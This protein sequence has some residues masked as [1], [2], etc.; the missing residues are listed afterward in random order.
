MVPKRYVVT[1]V[2]IAAFIVV[3]IGMPLQIIKSIWCSHSVVRKQ[4]CLM[5]L[6]TWEYVTFAWAI[7]HTFVIATVMAF[8]NVRPWRRSYYT[9]IKSTIFKCLAAVMVLAAYVMLLVAMET[10]LS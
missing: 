7:L 5:P 3:G 1:L 6:N 8:P 2:N 10:A 9:D 4:Q